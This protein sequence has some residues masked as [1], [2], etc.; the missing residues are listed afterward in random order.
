[1]GGF[2]FTSFPDYSAQ[3]S[4][5]LLFRPGNHFREF[6]SIQYIFIGFLA[7]TSTFPISPKMNA[8]I[9]LEDGGSQ[10]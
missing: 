5:K 9:L 10:V 7:I 3:R 1:M 6:L 8:G 2:Q 4:L